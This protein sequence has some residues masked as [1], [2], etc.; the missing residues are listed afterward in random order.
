MYLAYQGLPKIFFTANLQSYWRP[1]Y[2]VVTSV[3]IPTISTDP[4]NDYVNSCQTT[5]DTFHL[6][7]CD[8]QQTIICTF[9]SEEIQDCRSCFK[10]TSLTYPYIEFCDGTATFDQPSCLVGIK[11]LGI[12]S[13]AVYPENCYIEVFFVGVWEGSA[14][15]DPPPPPG[16][17]YKAGTVI[18]SLRWSATADF[19]KQSIPQGIMLN[20]TNHTIP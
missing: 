16:V 11:N 1:F 17:D 6:V 9:Q 13:P 4:R 7:F 3:P 20:C 10:V 19:M 14:V 8:Q 5:Y 15:L 2:A 18:S 12:G